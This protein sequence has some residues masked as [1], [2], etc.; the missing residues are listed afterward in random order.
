[1][2][3]SHPSQPNRQSVLAKTKK[4]IAERLRTR[5]HRRSSTRLRPMRSKRHAASQQRSTPAPFRR[6]RS[7]R[8]I[9]QERS[10]RRTNRRMN[11]IPNAIDIRNF[12][13]EKFDQV[14]RNG[15]TENPRMRQHLQLPRQMNHA[16]SLKQ[17]ESGDGRVKIQAGRESSTKRQAKS[18][19]RIHDGSL[20]PSARIGR[21]PKGRHL[22]NTGG[23]ESFFH[24]G[25]ALARRFL[26]RAG[27]APVSFQAHGVFVAAAL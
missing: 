13:R 10:R 9:G 20:A 3:G 26:R 21:R 8:T 5:I 23:T 4:P 2:H 14:Q 1:M 24:A 11:H 6:R 12:V 17:A 15:N 16:K 27:A 7:S 25:P 19:D 18:F 22:H